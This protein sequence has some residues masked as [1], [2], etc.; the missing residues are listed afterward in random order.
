VVGGADSLCRMTLNGF[1]AL[2][3]L[4]PGLCNPFSANRDGINIGEGAAAFLL[5]PDAATVNLLGAG[6]TSDAYHISAPDPDG[7]GAIG[8]MEQAIGDAAIAPDEI[9]YV[10]LHGT[11]TALNDA[12]ESRAVRA[13]F[14]AATPC[15]STKAMTGH[16]LGAA[17][18][19]EAAF[20]WLALHPAF[21]P[22]RLPPHLWDGAPDPDLPSLTLVE[23]GTPFDLGP[24][25]AMLSSS[26]AF[27]GNNVALV[28]GSRTP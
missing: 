2:E 26:F 17:G 10:N 22:G 12:M 25:A 6:E 11:G 21:N 28:L 18:A 5:T 16:T 1:G 7:A 3:A 8:A 9:A 23:P 13:I 24:G 20:L 14:P 4:S 27:G 15:S 19:V